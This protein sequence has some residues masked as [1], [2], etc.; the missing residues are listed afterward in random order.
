MCI[1]NYL[2]GPV[3]KTISYG[4]LPHFMIGFSALDQ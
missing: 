2:Q 3:H 1:I 4:E